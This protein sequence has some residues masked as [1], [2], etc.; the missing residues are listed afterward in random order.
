MPY[1]VFMKPETLVTTMKICKTVTRSVLPGK[2]QKAIRSNVKREIITTEER[3]QAVHVMKTEILAGLFHCLKLPNKERHQSCP[4]T[5]RCKYKNGLPCPNK[6]HH[7]IH[8][9]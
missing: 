9:S 6:P 8:K 2:L 5:S 3:D 4:A 7:D 1:G